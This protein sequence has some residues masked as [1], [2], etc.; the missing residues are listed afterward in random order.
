MAEKLATLRK[1]GGGGGYV[2]DSMI[3]LATSVTTYSVSC[4]VGDR[5]IMSGRRNIW[6]AIRISG[7]DRIDS[8]NYYAD[9]ADHLNWTDYLEATSSTVTVTI[10][11]PAQAVFWAVFYI[12]KKV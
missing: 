9:S 5:I 3:K 10:D 12:M 4:N 2:V 1:K 7:A 6:E 8:P 11:N